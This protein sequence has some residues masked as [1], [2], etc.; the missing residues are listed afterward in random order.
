ML[1]LEDEMI[2]DA[3]EL[4]RTTNWWHFPLGTQLNSRQLNCILLKLLEGFD[5]GELEETIRSEGI[6]KHELHL[7]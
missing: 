1:A 7:R 2:P 6:Q 5:K 4:D 3:T